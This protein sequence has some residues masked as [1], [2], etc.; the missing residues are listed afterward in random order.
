MKKYKCTI[1]ILAVCFSPVFLTAQL[2]PKLENTRSSN[3]GFVNVYIQGISMRDSQAAYKPHQKRGM[4]P[5][6]GF[7]LQKYDY[8][9]WGF[10]YRLNFELPAEVVYVAAAMVAKGSMED[11]D[12]RFSGTSYFTV[13]LLEYVPQV[14]VLSTKYVCAGLG[15]T[16]YDL[17]YYHL[18]YDKNGE[19][20]NPDKSAV[21]QYGI[22]GGWS[23]F[24]D[25]MLHK[26]LTL[27]AD[28]YR[29][30]GLYN[31]SQEKLEKLGE[32]EQPFGSWKLT[33]TLLYQN[34]L[35]ATVR[36]HKVIN[37]TSIPTEASR[38][39][40]GLGL[41]IGMQKFTGASHQSDPRENQDK[42]TF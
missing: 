20:E 27:H 11:P 26:S 31:A 2:T 35:F 33:A 29:G 15:G 39:Q 5:S 25:V 40:I 13:G 18:L 41:R 6:L 36:Y 21:S 4:Y 34:G 9:Q 42:Q 10:R 32:P 22:Y 7:E 19:P 14:S 28:F 8:A 24:A 30:Y 12:D 1:I 17:N 37:H 16:L 23:V 38:F 3:Q